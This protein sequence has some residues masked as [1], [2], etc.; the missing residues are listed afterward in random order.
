MPGEGN[1]DD[2]YAAGAEVSKIRDPSLALQDDKRMLAEQSCLS[3]DY[4]IAE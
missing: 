2:G 1:E 3:T 4:R